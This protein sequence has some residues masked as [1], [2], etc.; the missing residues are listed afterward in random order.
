[1]EYWPVKSQTRKTRKS[2]T[3]R[4]N[5][6]S[7]M[8][9]STLVPLPRTVARALL[10]VCLDEGYFFAGQTTPAYPSRGCHGRMGPAPCQI[11][12]GG[13]MPDDLFLLH[14]LVCYQSIF[15]R[16]QH[17]Q[18]GRR[19]CIRKGPDH[20]PDEIRY[21]CM[22]RP[23]VRDSGYKERGKI[24]SVGPLNEVTLQDLWDQQP[25]RQTERV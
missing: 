3:S 20:T 2:R 23:Y 5:G 17:D 21:A 16:L 10:N 13:R 24:L 12:G 25:K 18:T 22:S 14:M 19:M 8:G 1:M 6:R 7:D 15:L 4:V 9:C 11:G